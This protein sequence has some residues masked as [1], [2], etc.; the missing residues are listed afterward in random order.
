MKI[1]KNNTSLLILLAL[2]AATAFLR[3][4]IGIPNVTPIAAIAL[5][6]GAYIKRKEFA[7]LLPLAILF[8]SDLFIGV[9]SPVLMVGVYGS[10]VMISFLGFLL[11]K[12]INFVT[13]VGSSLISSLIFFLVTNF[14]VWAQ[15]LWYPLTTGGLVSCYAMAVP[16]FKYE[17]VGTLLFNAFFFLS[18]A[19][20]LRF[21]PKQ[22]PLNA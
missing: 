3:I 19:L 5:F 2:I 16:F 7:I 6:G 13:V 15:G 10:F 1:I 9:Y 14:V 12:K 4:F 8:V 17:A 21:V 18:Y 22:V 11:R 20:A